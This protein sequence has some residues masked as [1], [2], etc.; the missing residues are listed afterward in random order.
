MY[1]SYVLD[2]REIGK[3][4]LAASNIRTVNYFTVTFCNTTDLLRR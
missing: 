3:Y 2:F 4:V 1:M